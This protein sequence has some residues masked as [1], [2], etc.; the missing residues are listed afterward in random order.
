MNSEHRE[1]VMFLKWFM[2]QY[3]GVLIHSIPNGGNRDIITAKKL[4]DEGAIAGIPDLFIPKYN[5][6]IEM[7]KEK[8]GILSKVQKD[9]ISYLENEAGHTVIIGHGAMDAVS[10]VKEFM[11]VRV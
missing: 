5:L 6:W 1:Q 11:N 10:K 2:A 7:K 8:G 3:K 4:K 9:I